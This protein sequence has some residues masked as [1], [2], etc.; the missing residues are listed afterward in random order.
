MTPCATAKGLTSDLSEK[1]L[2][3]ISDLGPKTLRTH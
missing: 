1:K 2:R 3:D